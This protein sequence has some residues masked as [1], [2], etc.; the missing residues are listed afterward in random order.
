MD[1]HHGT[2]DADASMTRENLLDI[3]HKTDMWGVNIDDADPS[4]SPK[5]NPI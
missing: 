5:P 4:A 2:G 3:K 1:S